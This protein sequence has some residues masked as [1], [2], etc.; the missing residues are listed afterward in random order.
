MQANTS[1]CA[2]GNHFNEW[3]G[4]ECAWHNLPS[5]EQQTAFVRAYLER[6]AELDGQEGAVS[7]REVRTC[8]LVSS[9]PCICISKWQAYLLPFLTFCSTSAS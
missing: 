1:L 3:A 5:D 7:D 9:T 8:A 2:A 6:T 4:F